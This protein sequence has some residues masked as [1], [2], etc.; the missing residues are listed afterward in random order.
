MYVDAVRVMQGARVSKGDVLISLD[1]GD[2]RRRVIRAEARKSLL[3]LKAARLTDEYIE[4]MIYGPLMR[5][6]SLAQEDVETYAGMVK[7]TIDKFDDGEVTSTDVAS[8]R[9]DHAAAVA[10][11]TKLRDTMLRARQQI[12]RDRAQLKADHVLLDAEFAYILEQEKARLVTAPVGGIFS[13]SVA[14]GMFVEEG[15]MLANIA[16]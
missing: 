15:D 13:A 8:V 7:T 16:Y 9:G 2:L 1:Q 11:L 5:S 10:E 4:T 14:P 12:A 6:S 3:L